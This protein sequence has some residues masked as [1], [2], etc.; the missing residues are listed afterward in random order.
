M[1]YTLRCGDG[2]RFVYGLGSPYG[3]GYWLLK[4]GWNAPPRLAPPP[5]YAVAAGKVSFC[6]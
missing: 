3:D 5:K 1:L 4:P 6:D 2:A